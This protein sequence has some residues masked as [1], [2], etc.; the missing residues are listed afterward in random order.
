MEKNSET[1][2]PIKLTVLDIFPSYNELN[3]TQEEMLLIFQGLN[4]FF[5]LKEIL[6]IKKIIEIQNNNQLSIIVSLIK[7]N[8][9]IATGIINIKQGEQWITFNYE[10]KNK[11]TPSNLVLSLIDCIKLKIYV[12]VN[13]LINSTFNNINTSVVNTN[14]NVHLTNK[15]NKTKPIISQISLK[16][17]KRNANN[18]VLLKGSPLKTNYD[19]FKHR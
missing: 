7:S 8:N 18:K 14:T 3:P 15:A 5:D 9:I 4:H 19:I 2:N 13:N 10:N 1:N 17:S 12:E 16:I 11:K 6:S